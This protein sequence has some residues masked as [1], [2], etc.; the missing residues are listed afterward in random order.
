LHGKDF[1]LLTLIQGFFGGVGT[2]RFNKNKK[3]VLYSVSGQKELIEVIIPH[4]L[5]YPL[6]T[7]KGAD[8]ILFIKIIDLMNQSEHRTTEGLNKIMNIRA[9]M[10][11]GL[12]EKQ[13]EAFSNILPLDR[14]IIETV[15]I[16]DPN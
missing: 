7:Q 4:F 12:S 9:S 10:N 6:L 11:R 3:V 5:K 13:K 16:L 1:S 2:I 14:P 8:F 15:E